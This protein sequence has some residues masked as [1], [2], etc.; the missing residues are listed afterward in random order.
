VIERILPDAVAVAE[1]FDDPAD[2][3]LYPE[4]AV[5]VARAV[6]KRRREFATGRHCARRA[7]AKLGLP[8]GPVPPGEKGSPVWPAGV[9][10]SIT[11]CE[12]YR[13]A[14]VAAAGAVASMGIDAEPH[15]ELPEGVLRAISLPE[16]R[17][18]I[19]RRTEEQQ[20]IHWDR[21]LFCAKEAVYKAWFPLTARWLDF[22]EAEISVEPAADPATGRFVARLLVPG[23]RLPSPAGGVGDET[24]GDMSS[25]E[26]ISA[27][28][29]RWLVA[30]G[31]VL[32][33][34][35]LTA[36]AARSPDARDE[37]AA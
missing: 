6:D 27:F 26:T 23:P 19:E 4:E 9:V 11:H 31:L 7:L 12:G 30:D 17:R 3:Y 22:E 33:S 13:G 32:T 29:G 37:V 8:I 2:A 21:L 16:E 14:A 25:G 35:V 36:R 34:V 15:G 18:W 24:S 5:A 20:G 1:S 28:P 10:G